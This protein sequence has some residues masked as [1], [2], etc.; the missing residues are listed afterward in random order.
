[1]VRPLEHGRD[2][3]PQGAADLTSTKSS[4]HCG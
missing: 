2:I 4:S 3:L 1:L